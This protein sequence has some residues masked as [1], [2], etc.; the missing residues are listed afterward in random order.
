MSGGG[1]CLVIGGARSGKSHWA[2][3]RLL[4]RP[5]R[6]VATGYPDGDPQWRDRLGEHRQRRPAHWETNETLD[7]AGLLRGD[8]SRPV[9]VDCLTLWLTRTLDATRAWALRPEQATAIIRPHLLH[10]VDAVA[11]AACPV[12]LVTNEVGSGVV[13]ETA[14]GRLF[15]DL[16]GELNRRVAQVCDEVVLMVAGIPVPVKSPSSAGEGTNA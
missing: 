7:V 3:Q 8:D 16:L 6:Y 14:S 10:L 9:L 15:A 12:V 11:V 4:G 5:T 2:E 13:P 1:H